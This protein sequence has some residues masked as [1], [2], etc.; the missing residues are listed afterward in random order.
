MKSD[1][2]VLFIVLQFNKKMVCEFQA[3]PSMIS[4]QQ[5]TEAET[6]FM[7]FRRTKC[8]YQI[9]KYIFGKYFFNFHHTVFISLKK[10]L[11][12]IAIQFY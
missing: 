4:N 9:C 1:I 2:Y 3:P 10:E 8:P 6:I 5:R 12:L 7:N 11:F